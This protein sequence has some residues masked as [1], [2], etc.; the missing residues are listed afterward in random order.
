VDRFRPLKMFGVPGPHV[1]GYV[2]RVAPGALQIEL[3]N[4]SAGRTARA[5]LEDQP[6]DVALSRGRPPVVRLM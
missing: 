2:E 5:L 4:T 6:L 3:V 1:C